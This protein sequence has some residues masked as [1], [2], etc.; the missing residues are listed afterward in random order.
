MQGILF[1]AYQKFY[2]A[3]SALEQFDKENDF[4][5]NI[6]SLDKFLT[7]FRNVTW[8]LQKAIAHTQYADLYEKNRD[9]Y[10]NECR[11]FVDKRNE[12][13]KEQPFQFVKQIVISIYSPSHELDVWK[14][15]FTVENDVEFTSLLD[16]LKSFL[17]MGKTNEVFFSV[18]F[19]FYEKDTEE[20]LYDKLMGGVRA[21]EAFLEA[22]SQGIGEHC[23]LC[24][25]LSK[26]INEMHLGLLPQDMLF[27][28][29]YVYYPKD[30]Q[31]E[32]ADRLAISWGQCCQNARLPLSN[33]DNGF[34]SEMGNCYFERFVIMN[35][36]LKTADLMPTIW[37]VYGDNTFTIDVFHSN[38]KTTIYRKINELAECVLKSDV[39]EIYCMMTY[40]FCNE[41][42]ITPEMTSKERIACSIED[43]LTFIRVDE[44]LNEEEYVF[45]GSRLGDLEYVRNQLW[46]GKKNK[47][48]LGKY[49]LTPV[50]E[51]FRRR[52]HENR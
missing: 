28:T 41:D 34:F 1:S 4:F 45:E 17:T 10:L 8:V 49:N 48:E 44:D 5:D 26:K 39:K 6:A 15:I 52:S 19:C 29:D 16:S 32:R 24:D 27:V 25:T 47:L 2:S 51:A 13:T 3:L 21:M 7:E 46:N 9:K 35:T 12:V 40:T 50:I 31:F 20:D 30:N 42:A 18:K 14:E 23:P 36:I 22:M 38:L 37:T 11:W 33:L 43:Y